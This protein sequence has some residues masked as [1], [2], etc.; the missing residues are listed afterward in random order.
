MAFKKAFFSEY[1]AFSFIK[2]FRIIVRLR[3]RFRFN[4]TVEVE[5]VLFFVTYLIMLLFTQSEIIDFYP[6]FYE[7][8]VFSSPF[9]KF[10]TADLL[11]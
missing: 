11:L 9:K 10:P 5:S 3:V 2:T 4:A 7:M 1:F 8:F 6:L